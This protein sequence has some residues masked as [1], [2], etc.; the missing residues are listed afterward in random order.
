MDCPEDQYLVAEKNIDQIKD[1]AK[2]KTIFNLKMHGPMKYIFFNA[3]TLTYILLSI[4]NLNIG[5]LISDVQQH[6]QNTQC[7]TSSL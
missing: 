2:G 3:K 5:A 6:I 1:A 7:T 4:S